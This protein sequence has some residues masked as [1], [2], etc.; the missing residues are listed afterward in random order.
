MNVMTINLLLESIIKVY[1]YI[2]LLLYMYINMFN[3][4]SVFPPQKSLTVGNLHFL[5][6]I[7]QFFLRLKLFF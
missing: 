2:C 5:V 4:S 1:M 7:L 3:S 6:K